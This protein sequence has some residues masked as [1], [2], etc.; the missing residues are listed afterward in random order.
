M[1][2]D[3][4]CFVFSVSY[5]KNFEVKNAANAITCGSRYGVS[6]GKGCLAILHEDIGISNA[7]DTTFGDVRDKDKT[8]LLTGMDGKFKAL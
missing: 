1:K 8:S 3:S 7:V 4:S 5:K 6:F 2:K